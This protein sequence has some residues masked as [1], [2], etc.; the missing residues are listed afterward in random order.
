MGTGENERHASA[1]LGFWVRYDFRDGLSVDARNACIDR[2][3]RFLV[4][5][6]AGVCIG[7]VAEG[8]DWQILVYAGDGTSSMTSAD[9]LAAVA[10]LGNDRD[11]ERYDVGALVEVEEEY[12]KG[13]E[14][15]SET[16]ERLVAKRRGDGGAE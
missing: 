2:F 10:C 7:G 15:V 3:E 16:W 12:P 13:V 11:V 5:E 1:S 6:L 14:Q 4:K 8:W 9:R